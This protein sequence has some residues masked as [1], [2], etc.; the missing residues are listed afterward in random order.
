MNPFRRLEWNVNFP[1]ENNQPGAQSGRPWH[2][3]WKEV[4]PQPS[5]ASQ[6]CAHAPAR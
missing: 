4:Y 1:A 5:G 2:S 6:S 3:R